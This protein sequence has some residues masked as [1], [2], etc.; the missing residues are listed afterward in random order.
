MSRHLA[1][2]K[3]RPVPGKGR[4]RRLIHLVIEG[5]YAPEYWLHVEIPASAT[6]GNLDAFLRGTWLEC[7][8]HLS[9]FSVGGREYSDDEWLEEG[10]GSM[11]SRV[12]MVFGPGRG[13]RYCYDFGSS[14]DLNVRYVDERQGQFTGDNPVLLARNQQPEVT[15]AVCG[16]PA[17]VVCQECVDEEGRGWFC[18][19]HALT[20]GCQDEMVLPVVNSPRVGV[21]A[22]VGSEPFDYDALV[23]PG[24]EE[25]EDGGDDGHGDA[26]G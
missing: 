21:C 10:G 22:Y 19:A 8:G 18:A 1:A 6:L 23:Q 15:C 24:D 2:C 3:E 11:R 9:A 17:V 25:G 14:T 16:A 7:C 20:H 26:L 5:T 4:G 13:G 12:G